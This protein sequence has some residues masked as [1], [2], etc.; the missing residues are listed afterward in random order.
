MSRPR[1]SAAPDADAVR[2]AIIGDLHD[3][4]NDADLVHLNGSDY[5]GVI[6]VGDLGR[7]AETSRRISQSIARLA[8]PTLVMPGNAD[9]PHGAALAVEF[10]L[11]RGL[12]RLYGEDSG[13][14]LPLPAGDFGGVRLCGY[15]LHRPRL[16]ACDFTIV[17]GRPYSMGGPELSFGPELHGGFGIGSLEDSAKRL[18]ELV[19]RSETE[20]LVFLSHNGPVGLGEAP[21][22]PWSAD[23]LPEPAD[24]GDP[25]LSVA[26]DHARSQGRRVLAV[27]AGHMHLALQDGGG[28]RR[29]QQR[30]GDVLYVNPARVPRITR[31]DDRDWHHHVVLTLR[32]DGASAEEVFVPRETGV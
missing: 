16:P 19:D 24:W 14:A 13:P 15:S 29:W 4:W 11:R 9:A 7:G 27:V 20:A 21:A 22:D 26:V 32:T 18:C 6:F 5:D 30:D 8:L 25:D 31:R 10:S 23:F 17:A 2:L 28:E 3:F 1:P 12:D